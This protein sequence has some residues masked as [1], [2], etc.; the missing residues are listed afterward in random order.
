MSQRIDVLLEN[1]ERDALGLDSNHSLTSKLRSGCNSIALGRPIPDGRTLNLRL[2]PDVLASA[3]RTLSRSFELIR[4]AEAPKCVGMGQAPFAPSSSTDT[5]SSGAQSMVSPSLG[6]SGGGAKR[7]LVKTVAVTEEVELA[8]SSLSVMLRG[9][10]SD[11]YGDDDASSA[12]IALAVG[13]SRPSR[14]VT[15]RP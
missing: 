3:E 14:L 12:A 4:F 11:S 5:L 1:I 10:D 6:T 15:A 7:V 9:I 2:H 8:R 13:G